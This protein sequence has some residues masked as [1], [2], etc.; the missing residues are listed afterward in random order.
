MVFKEPKFLKSYYWIFALSNLLLKNFVGCF[1]RLRLNNPLFVV[2]GVLF[3]FALFNLQGTD[4][5][6]ASAVSLFNLA[7]PKAFVKNF[8]QILLEI[9]RGILR[10]M[11]NACI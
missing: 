8:F 5:S 1:F 3:V 11:R 2:Q 10:S 7:H 9:F 4:R 6:A